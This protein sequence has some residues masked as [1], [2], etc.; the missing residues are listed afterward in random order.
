MPREPSVIAELRRR[1]CRWQPTLTHEARVRVD[2]V[3]PALHSN[4]I[5]AVKWDYVSCKVMIEHNGRA[6]AGKCTNLVFLFVMQMCRPRNNMEISRSWVS[7]DGYLSIQPVRN[8]SCSSGGSPERKHAE[9]W[10]YNY[11]QA[12]DVRANERALL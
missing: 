9:L 10:P 1:D 6:L 2:H 3:P 4:P 12:G 5:T 7:D 8:S 11:V